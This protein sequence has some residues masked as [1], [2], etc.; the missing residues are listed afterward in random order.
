M[1]SPCRALMGGDITTQRRGLT[2]SG[3]RKPWSKFTQTIV[4]R[5]GWY[6]IA[7]LLLVSY[8]ARL[9]EKVRKHCELT[10]KR[11]EPLFVEPL[12]V[13]NIVRKLQHRQYFLTLRTQFLQSVSL[14]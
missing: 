9:L 7:K 1:H 8:Y 5:F 11:A 2:I 6:E 3:T 10:V 14:L 12:E 13:V 4:P